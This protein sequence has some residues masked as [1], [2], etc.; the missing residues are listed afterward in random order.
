M[1]FRQLQVAGEFPLTEY[2]LKIMDDFD[3]NR[4]SGGY[5]RGYQFGEIT[6]KKFL[7]AICTTFVAVCLAAPVSG[8]LIYEYNASTENGLDN[9]TWQPKTN[10]SDIHN[11]GTDIAR[12]W[13][14]SGNT[15]KSGFSTAYGGISKSFQFSG[16]GSGGTTA[17]YGN[18]QLP[19]GGGGVIPGPIGQAK[20]GASASFEMWIKPNRTSFN[21]INTREMLFETGDSTAGAGLYFSP[22]SNGANLSFTVRSLGASNTATIS[23]LSPARDLLLGDFIQIVGVVDPDAA[24]EKIRLYVKSVIGN[25]SLKSTFANYKFWQASAGA[26]GLGKVN[27]TS[28]ATSPTGAFKGDIAIMK[29]Y[30]DA[31]TDAQVQSAFD[32]VATVVPEP[33]SIVT[34]LGL[35]SIVGGAALRRKK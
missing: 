15:L 17:S 1:K 30:D 31:L 10:N 18:S 3:C 13:S 29:F 11:G 6:M 23:L 26:S 7:F 35:A 5:N 9:G 14:L 27:G 28:V 16:A 2:S 21:D 20:T 12:D 19:L 8:G 25:T 34:F 32:S 33:A 22:L 24:V 4:C